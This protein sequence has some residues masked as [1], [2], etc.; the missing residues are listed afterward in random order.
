MDGS[1]EELFAMYNLARLL[2][3]H[4]IMCIHDVEEFVIGLCGGH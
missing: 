4:M 2:P 1:V 3:E